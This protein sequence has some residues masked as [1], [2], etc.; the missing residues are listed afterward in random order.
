MYV[1][2]SCAGVVFSWRTVSSFEHFE[3][4]KKGAGEVRWIRPFSLFSSK[5]FGKIKGTRLVWCKEERL[6]ISKNIKRKEGN[7][8]LSTGSKE[9]T[10]HQERFSLDIRKCLRATTTRHYYRLSRQML[11][12]TLLGLGNIAQERLG[13][14]DERID[15][16]SKSL[17]VYDVSLYVLD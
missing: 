3:H 12:S 10:F 11:A 15:G 4:L 17:P 5:L 6:T 16:L 2:F 14:A 7:N 9:S 13:I 8:N 1:K